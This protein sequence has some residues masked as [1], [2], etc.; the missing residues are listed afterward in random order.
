MNVKTV[1]GIVALTIAANAIF[2]IAQQSQPIVFP[3]PAGLT[4]TRADVLALIQ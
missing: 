2:V 1:A 4:L 3:T